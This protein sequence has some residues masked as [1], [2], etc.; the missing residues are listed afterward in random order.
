MFKMK[1]NEKG[2]ADKTVTRRNFIT[3]T[4]AAAVA[5]AGVL[6]GLGASVA[7][8]KTKH[9]PCP[10]PGI[11]AKWD[12]E[13]D[14][15]IVGFGGA[16]ASAAIAGHDAGA[17]MLILEVAP[18]QFRGGNTACSGGGW[19]HPYDKDKYIKYLRKLC[20]GATKDEY[21]RDW[22]ETNAGI[23][24]WMTKLGFKYKKSVHDYGHFFT[25][26][27]DDAGA[28]IA[29]DS[30]I[31]SY[32]LLTA[33]GGIANGKA[34]FELFASEVE[35]R[36]IRVLYETRATELV[37]NVRTREIL[38]VKAKDVTGKE[39]AIKARR[40]V[41][42]ACGGFENNAELQ[43][44]HITPGVRSYPSGTPYNIGDGVYMSQKVGADIFHMAGIEW[45]GYGFRPTKS[46]VA[47]WGDFTRL[48]SGM[49]VNKYGK[50]FYNED[51][52][53]VHTKTFP[54][55]E[56]DGFPDDPTSLSDFKGF[57]SFLIID[58]AK[59]LAGPLQPSGGMGF[60]PSHGLYNWSKDNMT[61]INSGII[62][63]AETIKE[64]AAKMGIDPVA[65]EETVK[66]YNK[67]AATGKDPEFGRDNKNMRPIEVP[68]Y[69]GAELV[70]V[71]I[72]TQGGPKHSNK[73]G[74]VL[75]REDKAI[76]RL[77]VAGE[78]GS[79]Y[80]MMYHGSGNIAEAIMVGKLTGE[81]AAKEKAWVNA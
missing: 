26:S 40:G 8:A 15:V 25:T 22:A 56:F 24:D 76:P 41:I 30:G 45:V 44:S 80:S 42:L 79:V 67:Y 35:K 63:K 48:G 74:R 53:L 31:D 43:D 66:N 17:K 16:G 49:I 61:E 34:L 19:V 11:P 38:G 39:I 29:R 5:G 32:R 7:Q 69:Y 59:R 73:D 14:I 50:R 33:Q 81:N 6:A 1:E 55:L 70:L 9:P 72:N 60:F 27:T 71:Y 2:I 3:S 21:L 54:A 36:K 58:E 47:T 13:A 62:K 77:Y 18:K 20:F 57:P 64:L 65:L 12:Q 51:K 46:D 37:Q 68:P 52:K 4:G 28:G 78:C 10:T 23:L 75:D